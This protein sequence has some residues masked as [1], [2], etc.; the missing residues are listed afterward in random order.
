M[1]TIGF[2]E[3]QE[4][5]LRAS[6]VRVAL[7][8]FSAVALPLFAPPLLRFE[9]VLVAY[10]ACAVGFQIAIQRRFGGVARVLLGGSMD[11]AFITFLVHRLGTQSTPLV[12]S[13]VLAAMFNALVVAPWAA[14]VLGA[15]GV[16]AYTAV[17]CAEALR[18]LPYAPDV[19]EFTSFVPSVASALRAA[20]VVA[21]LVSVSTWVSDSDRARAPVP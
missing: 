2:A 1:V 17:S 16:V 20:V 11:V 9:W 10:A 6:S 19:P 15:L 5:S 8:L 7:G 18:W 14:R 13:Y 12:A 21:T 4:D 3:N